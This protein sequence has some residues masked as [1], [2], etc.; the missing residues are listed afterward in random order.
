M[1]SIM[2][3]RATRTI[4]D[5]VASRASGPDRRPICTCSTRLKVYQVQNRA[6]VAQA[7]VSASAHDPATVCL[8]EAVICLNQLMLP[9]TVSES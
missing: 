7:Y 8:D 1:G 2:K 4:R 6:W 3:A 5:Y 9:Y